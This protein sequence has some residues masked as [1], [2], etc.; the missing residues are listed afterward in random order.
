MQSLNQKIDEETASR[1]QAQDEYRQW[2]EQRIGL[3]V[4]KSQNDEA[5]NLEREKRTMQQLQSGLSSIT[6][7]IK[8]VKEQQQVNIKELTQ[9][10]YDSVQ[11][12]MKKMAE[13]QEAVESR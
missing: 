11:E 8:A 6:D 2:F 1:K 13:I 9:V 4:E 5:Q 7:I 12:T 10:T 3:V